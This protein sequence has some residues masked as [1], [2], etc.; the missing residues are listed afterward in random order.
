MADDPIHLAH[1]T[2]TV[3]RLGGGVA[4]Y[5]WAFAAAGL[6]VG[7]VPR[8]AAL[9]DRYVHQ[10]VPNIPGVD[11]L[12]ARCIG[13]R[14]VGYSP[15][16]RRMLDRQV[17]GVEVV[18][19]HGLRMLPSYEARRYAVRRGVPLVVSPHGQ[20]DPWIL[21]GGSMRK[22]VIGWLFEDKNL[23][24]AACIHTTSRSEASHVRAYHLNNPISV[25][26]IGL[27]VSAYTTTADDAT[28][29]HCWPRLAGKKR[30]LFLSTI[31][32]KKGLLRLA[33][34]WC[35]MYK[36]WPD[37]HLVVTGV[38]ISRDQD[39]A[40][41]MIADH[42]ADGH[43]TFTGPV[44]DH[45][46]K[47]QLLACCDLYVLPTDG[48]NFGIGVAEAL[49]SGLPVVTSNTTPWRDLQR[50]ECG[51]WID[52]G[53]EP[54]CQA[55]HEAMAL[56]DPHRRAMG[57]RGRQLIEQNYSWTTVASQMRQ[58]YRWVLKRGPKPDFV[59]TSS[60]TIPD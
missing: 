46:V 47:R 11:L 34:A 8:I 54:L 21:A 9:N 58:V 12:V 52:V 30:L 19:S 1:V 50:S 32:P 25:V 43:V 4:A 17:A 59:Y 35:R 16:L 28:I 13:S 39:M 3:S 14:R 37:W 2:P 26:P 60:Q 10:D 5:L 23:Q 57:Q 42:G 38:D 56:P 24:T 53:I 45:P 49:A 29:I 41:A 31:Y 20:L 15:M 48:E 18:H 6:K 55:L 7:L 44:T 36:D 40:K 27:D 22:R 51:W 33:E